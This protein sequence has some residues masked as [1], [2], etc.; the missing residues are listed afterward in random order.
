[1]ERPVLDLSV[2]DGWPVDHV[3]VGV[4]APDRVLATHGDPD[5]QFRLASISKLLTAWAT[6][7]AIE[8]GTLHLDTP[9]GPPG[10]TVRHLLAHASGLDFDS[11]TI[12]S[13]PARRR[14]YSN[15]GIEVLAGLL[16]EHAGMPFEAY[17][18]QGVFEPLGMDT[19]ELR[20]SPAHGAHSTVLDLLRFG[21]ELLEPTLLAPETVTMA[22]QPIWPALAGVLPGVG[23]FDPLPWG[24]G[25]E[26]RGRKK[27]HWTS[28]ANSPGTVGHFGG[29]GTFLWMD[30]TARRS[31]V[32]LTDRPFDNWALAHWPAVSDAAL[33]PHA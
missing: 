2:V 5:Q 18:R 14:I 28:A 6:L 12:L 8:E 31:C 10:S 30:P 22:F 21:R 33:A 9:G 17:L 11:E 27:P 23:R 25:F 26:I 29:S 32:C 16:T 3:A 19:T 24:L 13:A 15:T 4:T 1:M 7:I 20:G